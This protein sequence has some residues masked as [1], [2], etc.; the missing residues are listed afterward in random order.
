MEKQKQKI[1]NT[2]FARQTSIFD[3]SLFND[4]G[5]SIIGCGGIGSA[6]G[7]ILSKLGMKIFELWDFDR[8]ELVNLPNQ[9]FIEED[10]GNYKSIAL[11]SHMEKYGINTDIIAHPIPFD[12]TMKLE[13]PIIIC[14][15]DSMAVR[16]NVFEKA[17][18]SK[19]PKL[20]IDARMAGEIFEIFTI[21]LTNDKDIA[22]YKASL[23][24]DE[25]ASTVPCTEKAII[26]NVMTIGSLIACQLTK[27][28]KDKKYNIEL[29]GD[30]YN[31]LLR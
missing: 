10:L 12:N 8:V 27:V 4:Y 28:L 2:V 9:F 17:V 21:D 25:E 23:F 30:L 1:N 13:L 31:M 18:R 14:C 19:I 26:Y 20:F 5:I 7:I 29:T 15:A 6:V 22:Q 24:T 16:K 3:P 11:K